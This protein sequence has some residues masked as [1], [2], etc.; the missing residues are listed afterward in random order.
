[1]LPV[2]P[3]ID[4][5]AWIQI[6]VPISLKSVKHVHLP[7][8]GRSSWKTFPLCKRPTLKSEFFIISAPHAIPVEDEENL[9]AIC[10][11][12][13]MHHPLPAHPESTGVLLRLG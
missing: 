9:Q 5:L 12:L 1:M 6:M 7:F 4:V 10:C 3:S 13:G 2:L 11:L 8:K